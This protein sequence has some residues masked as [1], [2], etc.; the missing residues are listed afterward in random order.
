MLYTASHNWVNKMCGVQVPERKEFENGKR[1]HRI[2]Q[3]HVTGKIPDPR[4]AH[5]DIHF[6]IVEETSFDPR[7]KVNF[8]INEK[9]AIRGFVDG[10]DPENKRILEIKTGSPMWSIGQFVKSM[11]RKIYFVAL[12][13]YTESVLITAYADDSQWGVIKP[14]IYSV[15][16]TSRDKDEAMDW[17]MGAIAII[18]KGDFTGGLTDGKCLDRYCLYGANCQ[19]K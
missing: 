7:C 2:I 9:Y 10:H 8:Q 15:V 18:E 19:F 1:L 17:I 3:D 5:I 12:P 4:L 6:P 11:Q 16:P 13:N 14:K